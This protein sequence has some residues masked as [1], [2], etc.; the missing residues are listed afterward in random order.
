MT[1]IVLRSMPE[2]DG[3]LTFD[4]CE[5]ALAAMETQKFPDVVLLDIGLPG[6]D[7]I[8]GIRRFKALREDINI[9]MLTLIKDDDKIFR[10]VCAGA[11]GYLLKSSVMEKLPTAVQEAAQGGAPMTPCVARRVV[12]MFSQMTPPAGDSSDD[13]GFTDREREIL[14]C[15]SDGLAKKQI[16]DRLELNPHTLN[17]AIRRIYQKL[18]VNCL[19]SAVAAGLRM[20]LVRK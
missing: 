8:E 15:M 13:S 5:K 6:M 16:A 17:S 11:C 2:I 19:G 7:G 10:A 9:V 4:R 20:G 1:E 3:V 14:Q 12:E 18:R